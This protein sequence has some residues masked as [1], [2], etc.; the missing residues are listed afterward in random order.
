MVRGQKA[1][2]ASDSNPLRY[3]ATRPSSANIRDASQEGSSKMGTSSPWHHEQVP[4]L[5]QFLNLP[6][7][8]PT[9]WVDKQPT[10]IS[11]YTQK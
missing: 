4:H 7:S 1:P 6:P 3:H 5:S 9:Q 8:P 11:T 10:K 2:P